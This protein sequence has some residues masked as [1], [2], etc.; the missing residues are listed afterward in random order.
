MVRTNNNDTLSAVQTINLI[1]NVT[2]MTVLYGVSTSAASN[3][4]SILHYLNAS[5]MAATDWVH[6]TAV[7]VTLNLPGAPNYGPQ[8][9]AA[10]HAFD[11]SLYARHPRHE[12][13]RS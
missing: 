7:K 11:G 6:I 3:D 5:Q 4:Y 9:H 13:R 10:G 2:Q 8:R 12:P 1:P